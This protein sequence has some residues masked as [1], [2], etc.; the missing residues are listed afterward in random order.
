MKRRIIWV[1]V[2]CLMGLALLATSCTKAVPTPTLALENTV[3]V[4]KSYG[5]SGKLQ[6]VL[7]YA[8]VTALFD[9][10]TTQVAGSAG[11]NRYF[12]A[13]KLDGNKLIIPGST[14]VITAMAGPQPLM[15]Q[16]TEFLKSLQAAESYKIEGD[17]LTI[18]CGGKVLIF[19]K[20]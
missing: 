5:E 13:Y 7:P 19:T 14:L 8:E 4:L 11:V 16:E 6:S 17:K 20:K 3:W 9:S 15:D 10:G 12:G 1:V 18:T 2:S